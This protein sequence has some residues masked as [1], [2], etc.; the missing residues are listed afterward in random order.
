MVLGGAAALARRGIGHA[1]H[2]AKRRM[3]VTL[4]IPSKDKSYLW[5]LQWMA[6]HVPRSHHLAVETQ[7]VKP[8]G[9]RAKASFDLVPGLGKHFIKYGPCWIQV[10]R[11]RSGKI[12]D[13]TTGTPWETVT[14]T[15]LS[16]DRAIFTEILEEAREMALRNE[17]GKTVIYTAWST[18]WRP[19]GNPRTRRE[20]DS[21]VLDDGVKES[22]VADIHDFI[23]SKQWYADRGIPYRRG[24]LFH[25]PPGS[26]KTSFIYALAGETEYNICVLNL[27]ERGLTDDKLNY[28]MSN[29]PERCFLLLEDIDAVFIGRD[30]SDEPGYRSNVTFSGLLNAL[31]GVMS[32]EERIVFMTTNHLERLDSA[33]IRPGRVDRLCLLDNATPSQ[34]MHMFLRF[35]EGQ[36][37]LAQE[38][39]KKIEE[40]KVPISTAMLQGLFVYNKQ[41]PQAAVAMADTLIHQV[42]ASLD[43]NKP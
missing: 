18:E 30:K 22:I 11:T 12:V 34:M 39:S 19:F 33:L 7:F 20:L 26:G 2:E 13:L 40:A 23:A 16:R 27:A 43:E 29:L 36:H 8:E 28:L 38:F 9:G 6:E 41:D 32:A 14:M 10:E 31:D 17:Q 1:A 3:L 4:E 15:T 5:F 21:V 25:G 35:Y 24:Y 37:D 42:R